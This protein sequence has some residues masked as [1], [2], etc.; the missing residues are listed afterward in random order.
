MLPDTATL[1]RMRA[2]DWKLKDIAAEYGV[3]EAAVWKALE[4]ANLTV[5]RKTYA[6][7]LPWKIEAEHRATS[8]MQKFRMILRKQNGETL[9]TN[10]QRYL[11]T[12][13]QMLQDSGVVVNYHPEAPPNDASKKGG[14]YYVAREPGDD[15]IIR[16]PAD[17]V[18]KRTRNDGTNPGGA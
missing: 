9:G 17:D 12:W 8:I 6:D 11:D 2:N 16:R 4:R 5:G 18:S 14:F 13:L 3:S 1:R 10:E 15:W 7:I